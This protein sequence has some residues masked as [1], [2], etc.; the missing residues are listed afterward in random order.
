[1]IDYCESEGTSL[2]VTATTGSAAFL[3][4]GKTVHSFLGIGLAKDSAKDIFAY[5]RY[6]IYY[7]YS[8]NIFQWMIR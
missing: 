2:G 4:G 6:I 8:P 5:A 3:I 1:M 7:S